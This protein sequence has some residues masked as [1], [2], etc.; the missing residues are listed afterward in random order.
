MVSL[1]PRRKQQG[2]GM[3][4]LQT[5]RLL[6]HPVARRFLFG[7][8]RVAWGNAQVIIPE[9]LITQCFTR[10]AFSSRHDKIESLMTMMQ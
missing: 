7:M 3:Q 10:M 4:S 6:S 1:T 2:K 9:L 5:L 8:A